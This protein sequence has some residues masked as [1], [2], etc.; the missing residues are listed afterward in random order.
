MS[1]KRTVVD[2]VASKRRQEEKDIDEKIEK[3]FYSHNFPYLWSYTD[4]DQPGN[5]RILV[6][7][8]VLQALFCTYTMMHPDEYW[9][10]TQPAYAWVYPDQK[11][12]LPWEWN[13]KYQLRNTI[14][15]AY[16]AVWMQMLKM[17]SLDTNYMVRAIPYLAHCPL[18]ILNDWFIWKVAKRVVGRDAAR[19]SMI[20]V[21]FNRFQ[22]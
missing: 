1:D 15:P 19:F 8:R 4:L 13:D 22:T 2:I 11:V 5:F 14:Y 20:L 18:V 10:A 17:I 16:L 9:Q 12:S 21:T 3:Q 7:M 6:A